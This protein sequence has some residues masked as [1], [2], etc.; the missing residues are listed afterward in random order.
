MK[1]TNHY[2]SLRRFE[3]ISWHNINEKIKLIK[4]GNCHSNVISLQ[5]IKVII[6]C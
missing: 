1:V 3:F 4:L 5:K 2:L 6:V